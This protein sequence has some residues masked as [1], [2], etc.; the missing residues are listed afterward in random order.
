MA[1]FDLISEDDFFSAGKKDESKPDSR[2]K[3]QPDE[4]LFAKP[5]AEQEPEPASEENDFAPALDELIPEPETK[6]PQ[7]FS[8]DLKESF[9]FGATLAEEDEPTIDIPEPDS[10][11]E[12]D[13]I[14]EPETQPEPVPTPAE[15]S[16]DYYD[17]KQEGINYKPVLYGII[18]LVV[19]AVLGYFG[20]TYFWGGA[21]G[22]EV[23]AEPKATEAVPAQTGPSPEEQ[24]VNAYY[25]KLAGN[26]SYAT[27][28]VVGLSEVAGKQTRLSSV[29]FYGEDFSFEVF[30]K[31][32]DELARLNIRLKQ[33]YKKADL[34][35]VSSQ[36]RPGSN[37]GVLAVYK[38][39]LAA[40]G[41]AGTAKVK[42]FK[43]A[44][45]GKNWIS[46]MV[47]N[48]NLKQTNYKTR[49]LG[50][51]DGFTVEEMDLSILGSKE[52]LLQ[53]ITDIGSGNRNVK[54]SKLSMSAI[55]KKS[56]NTKK[57]Q[58]RLILQLFM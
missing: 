37:G 42:P 21:G 38:M 14:P 57:Y 35:V 40:G 13:S 30:A 24:R 1:K 7:D 49:S 36:N 43:T 31:N 16:A 19:V 48:N 23:A 51:R 26:T 52:K 33:A 56:F 5:I 9:D 53:L 8:E 15:N 10:M 41:A 46:Y 17:D 3:V 55:D 58:L 25:S 12:M 50:S 18:A 11:P 29:L 20:Y 32:R 47:D 39:R 54:I 44:A 28:E 6:E 22:P 34:K 2:E 4:D 45:E 27:G